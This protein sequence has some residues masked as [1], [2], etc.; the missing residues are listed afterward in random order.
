[1]DLREEQVFFRFPVYLLREYFN[2]NET[3]RVLK[4]RPKSY[5][6]NEVY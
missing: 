6:D 4:S 3:L 1:M 5:K 2:K